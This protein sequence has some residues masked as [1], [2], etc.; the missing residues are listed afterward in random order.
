MILKAEIS[1]DDIV[2]IMILSLVSVGEQLFSLSSSGIDQ[3]TLHIETKPR[4]GQK[5]NNQNINH[6]Q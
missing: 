3:Y 5:N 4:L 6:A 2:M 1:L